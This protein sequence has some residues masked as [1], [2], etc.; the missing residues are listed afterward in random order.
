M[1]IN[2]ASILIRSGVELLVKTIN[3][4]WPLRPFFKLRYRNGPMFSY[5]YRLPGERYL[6]TGN[7]NRDEKSS[8]QFQIKI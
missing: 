4:I 2:L 5:R 1:Q 6:L 3:G 7:R 8:I